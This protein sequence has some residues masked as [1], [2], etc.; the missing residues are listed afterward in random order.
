MQLDDDGDDF[1]QDGRRA[2]TA[3]SV[4]SPHSRETGSPDPTGSSNAAASSRHEKSLGLLTSR[5]VSLLQQAPDGVLDLKHAADTLAVR[6]KRR[7]YDITNVLEGI[8]LIE[9]KSKNSIQWKGA[10]PGSNSAEITSRSRSLKNKLQQLEDEERDLDEKR[11]W[12]QQSLRN[13]SEDTTNDQ[14]AYI[15]HDD[16]CHIQDFQGKTILAVQAPS[17]TE[18]EVPLATPHTGDFGNGSNHLCQIHLKS[19]NGPINVL[20]V[21]QDEA[22]SSVLELS[23]ASMVDIEEMNTEPSSMTTE[24]QP[25]PTDVSPMLSS[26]RGAERE[27]SQKSAHMDG[28]DLGKDLLDEIMAQE[29]FAPLLRLSP[30]PADQDYFFNLEESEG[31]CD[32]FDVPGSGQTSFNQPTSVA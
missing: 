24:G 15:T 14:Y 4:D 16:L 1:D 26:A 22:L 2:S 8:G 7:I 9:K 19:H 18:L 27:S 20:L 11:S 13:V 28:V 10:G 3:A 6:Q 31:V 23:Q 30:P 12:L 21:D 25:L 17:G 5:F 29:G 32:L